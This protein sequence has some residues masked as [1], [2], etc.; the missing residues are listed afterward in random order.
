MIAVM[1]RLMSALPPKAASQRTLSESPHTATSG[2]WRCSKA[3]L[4]DHL[5]GAGE[6]RLRHSKVERLGGFQI[7]NQLELC[8]QLNGQ[9]LRLR[10]SQYPID[11]HCRSGVLVH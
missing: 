11:V 1:R 4:F 8:W 6:Q 3:M 7:D 10:A 5:V 9:V 2:H